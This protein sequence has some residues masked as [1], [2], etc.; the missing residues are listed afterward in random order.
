MC[1]GMAN[2]PAMPQKCLIPLELMRAVTPR[3]GTFTQ[4]CDTLA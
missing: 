1:F 4:L 3:P 2:A